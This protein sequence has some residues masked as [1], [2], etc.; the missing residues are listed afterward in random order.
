MKLKYTEVHNKYRKGF[1]EISLVSIT[2]SLISNN[3]VEL[4][5]IQ[6]TSKTPV[7]CLPRAS[8]SSLVSDPYLAGVLDFLFLSEELMSSVSMLSVST[9]LS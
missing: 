3:S 6:E 1:S 5:L 8:S 9:D 4:V 7:K 2:V